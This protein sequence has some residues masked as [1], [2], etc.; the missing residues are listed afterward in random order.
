MKDMIKIKM[1]Y[2]DEN[3]KQWIESLWATPTNEGYILENSPFYVLGYSLG[4]LVSGKMIHG[5]LFVDE[6]LKESGNSTIHLIFFDRSFVQ[7]FRD[8]LNTYGCKSE[9]SDN[10]SLISMNVPNNVNYYGQIKPILDNY[11][12]S[13]RLDY[14]EACLAHEE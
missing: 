3:G 11:S 5:E 9:L 8:E 7:S 1:Y 4:D 14:Q 13:N 10:P 6:L 12:N 2:D